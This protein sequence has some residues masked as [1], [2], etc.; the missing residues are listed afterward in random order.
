MTR[1]QSIGALAF[2]FLALASAAPT[3]EASSAAEPKISSG[4]HPELFPKAAQVDALVQPYLD[5]RLL[6]GLSIAVVHKGKTFTRHYGTLGLE[7]S[8]KPNDRTV[9]EIGS[10]SKVFTSLLLTHAVNGGHVKLD[11]PIGSLM[12]TVAE[13]NPD[14]AE[15]ITLQHLSQHMSG[16]PRLA[17][18]MKPADAND[19]YADYGR[20]LLVELME[21]I[22]PQR[23]PG[24]KQAYSNLGVGLLGDLLSARAQQEY[25]ALLRDTVLTDLDMADSGVQVPASEGRTFAKPHCSGLFPGHNW[26]WQS[27]VGAGGV[28]STAKDMA[29]FAAA[30]L[31]P[32][33]GS[34]GRAME[35]AWKER[36]PASKGELAMGLG[37]FLA[38]DGKTRWHNGM[39]GG[40]QSIL[41]VNR[42][43][44]TALVLLSNTADG[45]GDA[46]G[47]KILRTVLGEEVEPTIIEPEPEFDPE[48][49]KR[50]PGRYRLN[51]NTVIEVVVVGQRMQVQFTGQIAQRVYPEDLKTWKYRGVKA[52]LTFDLDKG[53]PCL[54]VTLHQNWR[55]SKATRIK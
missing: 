12:P 14:I 51:K 7:D 28:Q 23:K 37:W 48:Q 31:H 26:G 32:P 29:R 5:Q 19:P 27:M 20:G 52:K 24:E 54:Q 22:R 2:A 9:Y 55:W 39:T 8:T 10:I 43:Q 13:K 34:L 6:Q 41:Y 21:Q 49:L 47:E 42:E 11:Q 50:L 53:G 44:D 30:W 4:T 3:Q 46:L 15:S 40:F 33:E 45:Q 25:G 17:F 36:R 18:N 16:L 35:M 38:K 1:F